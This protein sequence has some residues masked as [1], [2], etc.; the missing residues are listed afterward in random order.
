MVLL[1]IL[2]IIIFIDTYWDD[3]NITMIIFKKILFYH[4][5]SM[6]VKCVISVTI[7]ILA[8]VDL[9]YDFLLINNISTRTKKY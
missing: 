4:T 3:G 5:L 9:F 8:L 1:L 6:Y 2:Q 7:K